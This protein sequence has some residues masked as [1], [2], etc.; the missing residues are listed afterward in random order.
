MRQLV[1]QYGQQR[2][3]RGR[4]PA[5]PR[6]QQQQGH[7]PQHTSEERDCVYCSNRSEQ[8]KQSRVQCELCQV[9]LCIDCFR[10][11]HQAGN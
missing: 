10:L 7:W 11:Y 5:T 8:R 3:R 2:S 9:H 1:E 4:P 6:E